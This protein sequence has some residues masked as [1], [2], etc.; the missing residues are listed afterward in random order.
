MNIQVLL[1]GSVADVVGKSK[2]IIND[3]NDTDSLK[4]KMITE[5]PQLN[6][7]VFLISVNKRL[8]KNNHLLEQG[9]EVAFLPPFAGG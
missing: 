1:F 2:L 9:N 6:N 8:V 4:V 3:C 5:Y 7:C